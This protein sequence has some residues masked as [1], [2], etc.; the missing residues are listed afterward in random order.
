MPSGKQPHTVRKNKKLRKYPPGHDNAHRRVPQ[1]TFS[2]W[3][4]LV[5][6]LDAFAKTFDCSRIAAMAFAIDLLEDCEE[7]YSWE[8][9]RS[10]LRQ[11]P[12]LT[13]GQPG[14]RP[15]VFDPFAKR[16]T[17]VQ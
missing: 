1:I 11:Y 9:I 16:G 4:P 2:T 3:T 14:Y 8:Y 13:S 6:R 12:R 7:R 15:E 10:R 5:H 17:D